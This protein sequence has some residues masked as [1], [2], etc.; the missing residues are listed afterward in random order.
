MASREGD[1]EQEREDAER[2]IAFMGYD[3]PLEVRAAEAHALA[4]SGVVPRIIRARYP[5][6]DPSLL[7]D[8]VGSADPDED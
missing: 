4:E 2:F 3:R 1:R 6:L 7:A 8:A 5:R